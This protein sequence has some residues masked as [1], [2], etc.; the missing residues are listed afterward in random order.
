MQV[1]EQKVA[2]KFPEQERC[3]DAVVR[4]DGWIAV[5]DGAT[6]KS[7]ITYPGPGR[8]RVSGGV[9]AVRAI[10]EILVDVGPMTDPFEATRHLV[11]EFDLRLTHS[12]ERV[13]EP[14]E[15][16]AASLAVLNVASRLVWRVGDCSVRI[17]SD[18][19]LGGK[20][21]DRVAADFRAALLQTYAVKGPELAALATHERVDPGREAILPLLRRQGL[22]ANSPG[23]FGY[24]VIDGRMVPPEFI[25]VFPL[26]QGACE[27]VLATDGYPSLPGSLEEAELELERLLARDPD[28]VGPLRSTKGIT[29]G[30][31]SFD[32]RAWV[33]VALGE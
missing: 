13:P 8:R 1:L 23:E 33:R 21:V 24:G 22:L 10:E 16:P 25:E 4:G 31:L 9:F 30:T 14:E 11:E 32:D 18:V 7:G 29:P 15:R 28:C 12:L 20:K 2:G 26:A 6:D 27:V 3:E 5:V 19:H 17:N